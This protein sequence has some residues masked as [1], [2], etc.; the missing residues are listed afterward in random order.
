MEGTLEGRFSTSQKQVLVL[1]SEDV[2]Y[3]TE[4]Y[5]PKLGTGLDN[6]RAGSRLRITGVCLVH[7]GEDNRLGSFYLELRSPSDITVLS[8]P[9]WWNVSHALW[10]LA[11]A[12]LFALISF[13]WAGILRRRVDQQTQIIRTTLESTA[14]GI[15]VINSQGKIVTYNQKFA[16]M[17]RIPMSVLASRDGEAVY[18]CVLSQLQEPEEFLARI[19]AYKNQTGLQSDDLVEFKDGRV[20][21][22]HSEP[23]R[24]WRRNVGR[25][26]AFRD[27]TARRRTQ[28][29]LRQSE[30]KYREL[31]ERNLAGVYR[32]SLDGRILDINEAGAR[33]F[34]FTCREEILRQPVSSMYLS[35]ADRDAFLKLMKEQRSVANFESQLRKVDGGPV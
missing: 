13:S 12:I 29:A 31:F 34:G 1:K 6:L 2:I 17:W 32:T 8:R 3:H 4:L 16:E 21:E 11:G 24:L 10:I 20:F 15:V 28:E 18:K 22:R 14:D 23:L 30:E 9:P 5:S 27:I 33:I 7:G 26:S 35:D 25:V 19:Q